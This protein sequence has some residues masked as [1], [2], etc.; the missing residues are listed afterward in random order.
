MTVARL[1]AV[2]TPKEF[3]LWCEYLVWEDT[4][5]DKTDYYF[6]GLTAEVRRS[7]VKQESI[8]RIKRDDFLLKY[9]KPVEVAAK[10][11][12]KMSKA[13]WFGAL[14]LNNK[15]PKKKGKQNGR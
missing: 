1:R 9:E 4:H 8:A 6:A 12:M 11:R 3:A 15:K 10:D 13:T 14:G 7:Y 2:I 5:Y